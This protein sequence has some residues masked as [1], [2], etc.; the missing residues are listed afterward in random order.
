[1]GIV[2]AFDA[3]GVPGFEAH[4]A[5]WHIIIQDIVDGNN[6]HTEYFMMNALDI[7]GNALVSF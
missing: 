6:F 2:S 5:A 7:A 1:M 3:L 4:S